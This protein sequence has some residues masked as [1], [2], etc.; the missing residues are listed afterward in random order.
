MTKIIL[1]AIL[2]FGITSSPAVKAQATVRGIVFED[3]NNNRIK[4]RTEAGIPEVAVSNGREVVLTNAAGKY[5]L[6]ISR[7]NIIFVIRPSG[8]AVALNEYNLPQFYYIYKPNGSPE[9]KFKGTPPTGKL[10]KSLNFGL[11]KEKNTDN[12]N[13]LVFGDPQ[14]C[15][16]TEVDYFYRGIIKELENV[17]DVQFGMSLGDLVYDDLTIFTPY[18]EA[19]KHIGIPWY[20]VMGN[21]DMNFDATADSLS[22]ETFESHFG[23]STYSFNQGMVHF[24]VLD[25]ILYPD[26][27]GKDDYWGGYTPRQLQFV[28]NDLKYVPKDYL[29]VVS[30][31][32]PLSEADSNDLFSDTDR[33]ELFALLKDFPHTLSLSGHTHIQRQDF[34]TKADGWLQETRHHHFNVG[35]TSGSWYLGKPDGQG[36]PVSTMRDGT[37]K[38]YAYIHFTKNTYTIDY[39]VA[40]KPADYQFE[41]FAPKVLEQNK[42]TS[43]GIMANFFIG[44][45]YDTLFY[46][47]D[48]SEWKKMLKI[49]TYDPNYFYSVLE[50]DFTDTLLPGERP[51]NPVVCRHLWYGPI[52]PDLE[53]GEH[54]IEVKAIDMF[55]RIHTQ[56]KTYRIAVQDKPANRNIN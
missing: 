28:R 13:I 8:Y 51:A 34:F 23:P 45:K 17:R 38:G 48:D 56:E 49:S 9:Q 53:I 43:S 20:N 6:P 26:P 2:L 25:D 40:G 11:I 16:E 47:I 19:L 1:A 35:T 46:R 21:H 55:G 32:I 10:P 33:N 50:W 41:I 12:F 29:I 4:D 42:N 37:L 39:K 15:D 7:D 22:D 14:T 27:R 30:A 36:V 54:T 18:K 3:K 44:G 31:H 5:E 24:I 52:D